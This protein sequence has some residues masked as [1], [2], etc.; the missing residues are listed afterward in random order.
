MNFTD[1]YFSPRFDDE[2]EISI[3]QKWEILC[4]LDGENLM[5]DS[6]K[7]VVKATSEIP[8]KS[9]TWQINCMKLLHLLQNCI[10]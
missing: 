8:I 5:E 1:H 9:L 4:V 6:L 10:H 7:I 2:D 3:S